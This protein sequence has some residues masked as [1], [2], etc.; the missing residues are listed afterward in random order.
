MQEIRIPGWIYYIHGDTPTQFDES[1]VGKWMYFFKDHF[2]Y[3]FAKSMC[4][5]AVEN[6]ILKEAKVSCDSSQG[7]S[8]FYSEADDLET[9]KRIIS[10]FIDHQIPYIFIVI[11]NIN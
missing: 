7:V 11:N 9:Q 6:G 8:C 2:G 10:F 1:K 4:K 3:E 5:L